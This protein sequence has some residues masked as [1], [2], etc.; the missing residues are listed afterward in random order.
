LLKNREK[1][2]GYDKSFILIL[3]VNNPFEEFG[4][5]RIPSKVFSKYVRWLN[6][7]NQEVKD[8]E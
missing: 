4:K 5:T 2:R 6:G 1:N 3:L 8:N 7:L